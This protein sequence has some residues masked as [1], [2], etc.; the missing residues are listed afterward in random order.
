[1]GDK[2]LRLWL[3]RFFFGESPEACLGRTS[4]CVDLMLT[5]GSDSKFPIRWAAPSWH[6]RFTGQR[7]VRRPHPG[8]VPAQQPRQAWG[9]LFGSGFKGHQKQPH[10]C[11]YGSKLNHYIGDRRFWSMFPLTRVPVGVPILDSQPIGG[12]GTETGAGK[13]HPGS[14]LLNDSMDVD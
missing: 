4:P 12:W 8:G 2:K 6:P 1:M 14:S 9:G 10:P 11:G 3:N 5:E 13:V 7:Q